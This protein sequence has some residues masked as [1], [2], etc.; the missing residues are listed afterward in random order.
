[1]QIYESYLKNPRYKKS[2]DILGIKYTIEIKPLDKYR[3]F[4]KDGCIGFCESYSKRIILCDPRTMDEYW[5]SESDDIIYKCL[6]ETLRHE[7]I[8]AFLNESGLKDAASSCDCWSKNEEMV[9]WFAIM[10]P[11]IYKAY[12]ECDCLE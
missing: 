10:S 8:H 6:R 5:E 1:M 3:E 2:I 11:R 9:D 4:E 7:I 12:Q